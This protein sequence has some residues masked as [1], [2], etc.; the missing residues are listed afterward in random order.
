MLDKPTL[1]ILR[2]RWRGMKTRCTSALPSV[3]KNYG[4]RGIRVCDEWSSFDAFASYIELHVGIP[5]FESQRWTLDRIEND[6][7]YEPGNVRWATYKQNLRNRR[8]NRSVQWQGQAITIAELADLCGQPYG[9]LMDRIARRGWS[10]EKAAST[11]AS[12]TRARTVKYE[13][14][15][16]IMIEHSGK[17]QSLSAWSQELGFE[18]Q[19]VDGRLRRGWTFADAIKLKADKGRAIR[20]SAERFPYQ[21]QM[22]TLRELEQETGVKRA[23]LRYRLQVLRLPVEVGV[24]PPQRVRRKDTF[25]RQS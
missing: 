21:G 7:G 23:T 24:L 8:V 6:K 22:L 14:K 15:H 9:L 20:E 11:P 17:T 25:T 4:E 10:P 5:D 16:E 2:R 18:K 1:K 12:A 13:A 19:L 3:A